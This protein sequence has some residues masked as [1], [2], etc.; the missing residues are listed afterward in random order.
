MVSRVPDDPAP[1]TQAAQYSSD[2]HGAPHALAIAMQKRLDP[3]LQADVS[4][5]SG[6]SFMLQCPLNYGKFTLR[7]SFMK[8]NGTHLQIAAA[9][10]TPAS[11]VLFPSPLPDKEEPRSPLQVTCAA[12]RTQ[13]NSIQCL[14][15]RP[16]GHSVQCLRRPMSI[17]TGSM[18]SSPSEFHKACVHTSV[19]SCAK[20]SLYATLYNNV[21]LLLLTTL[22]RAYLGLAPFLIH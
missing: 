22:C 20:I 12:T 17:P 16:Q 9:R 21:R 18:R 4:P 1:T 7:A 10:D 8:K 14:H 15:I 6:L 19:P 13:G 5:I 11:L 2:I 3:P